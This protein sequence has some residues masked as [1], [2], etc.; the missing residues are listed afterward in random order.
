M[1]KLTIPN[2]L[3][4]V[5]IQGNWREKDTEKIW[6]VNGI[7]AERVKQPKNQM[8]PVV[9]TDGPGGVE[10]G[11]GNLKGNLE[12]GCIVWR[13]RRGDATFFWEKLEEKSDITRT[14]KVTAAKT[15]KCTAPLASRNRAPPKPIKM[16]NQSPRS[17]ISDTSNETAEMA[18]GMGSLVMDSNRL[19]TG[20]DA[21]AFDEV[22]TL[23]AMAGDR[24]LAGDV[25]L[26][27]KYIELAQQIQPCTDSF[28]LAQ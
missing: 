15:A 1:P 23:L 27:M 19:G 6:N 20:L 25:Y 11:N 2:V 24:L 3:S 17:T 9:L 28:D 12:F 26:S 5:E 8:K 22:K 18:A 16:E 10:W 13:N 21:Y 7:V 14:E 4:V